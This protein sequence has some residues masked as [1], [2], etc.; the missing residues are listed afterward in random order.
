MEVQF[1][2]TSGTAWFS[3]S[4]TQTQFGPGQYAW[5]ANGRHSYPNPDGPPLTTTV[6]GGTGAT[7]TLPAE[8]LTAA[9]RT[10]RHTIGHGLSGGIGRGLRN[11]S[12]I[13]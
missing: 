1:D 6:S 10:C 3:G 2:T 13:P 7:Y 8:S 11:R 5:I 9:D 12:K 4:V